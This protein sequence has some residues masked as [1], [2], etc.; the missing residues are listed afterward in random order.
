MVKMELVYSYTG[1]VKN[2]TQKVHLICSIMWFITMH[3]QYS[4][5]SIIVPQYIV[6]FYIK[7]PNIPQ[8]ILF[9]LSH[10]SI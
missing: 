3:S 5:K 1:I 7:H 9:I 10:K 2:K 4:I 6:R 8:C